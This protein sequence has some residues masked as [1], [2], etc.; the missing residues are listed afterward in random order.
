[1]DLSLLHA[2][3]REVRQ[4]TAATLAAVNPVGLGMI[5]LP[6]HRERLPRMSGLTGARGA[7]F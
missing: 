1:M 6:G 3:G 2:I 5:G 4:R 7:G